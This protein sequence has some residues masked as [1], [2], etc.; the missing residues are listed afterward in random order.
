MVPKDDVIDTLVN[1]KSVADVTADVSKPMPFPPNS[2]DTII[3]RHILEHLTDSV[4]ILG[5]WRGLLKKNGRI[6]IAVPDDCVI[7]SIPLNVEHVHNFSKESMKSLLEVVGF[8]VV[9]QLDGGNYI[10]FITV[11][12]KV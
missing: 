11:G 8:K 4:T 9:E 1:A 7:K 3:A 12:E 2:V 10:S 6:I 5:N